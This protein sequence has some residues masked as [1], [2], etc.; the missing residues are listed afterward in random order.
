MKEFPARARSSSIPHNPSFRG[1]IRTVTSSIRVWLTSM[2]YPT[3]TVY[4]SFYMNPDSVFGMATSC[5]TD[6]PGFKSL[7]EQG[8]SP[9]TKVSSPALRPAQLLVQWLWRA[10][11]SGLNVDPWPPSSEEGDNTWRCTSVLFS[12]FIL[13]KATTVPSLTIF[14]VAKRMTTYGR[15]L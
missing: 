10:K 3:L 13:W 1:W 2:D 8:I 4:Y 15:V 7:Q 5:R 9:S 14:L 11:P 6:G 12:A